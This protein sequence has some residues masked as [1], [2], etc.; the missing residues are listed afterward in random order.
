MIFRIAAYP[1]M[2]ALDAITDEVDTM[3]TR[4]SEF[5]SSP[6]QRNSSKYS[7]HA[8]S[9]ADQHSLGT[10]SERA[11]L[12]QCQLYNSTYKVGFDYNNG[13]QNV[14]VEAPVHD[15]DIP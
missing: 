11:T 15:T 12:I 6:G 14:E 10:I 7:N 8:L 4:C 5:P 9:F 2:L 3:E 13:A 1:G